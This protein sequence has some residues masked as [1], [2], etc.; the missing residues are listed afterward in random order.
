MGLPTRMEILE[1]DLASITI[2]LD[3]S[4]FVAA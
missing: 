1:P 4:D 2:A 3:E